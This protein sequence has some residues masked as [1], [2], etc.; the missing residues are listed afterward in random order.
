MQDLARGPHISH[1]DNTPTRIELRWSAVVIGMVVGLLL[2]VLFM[3]GV[4]L[5]QILYLALHGI[6][7]QTHNLVVGGFQFPLCA[8]DSGMYLSYLVTLGVVVARGRGLAGRLPPLRI[9]LTILLLFVIMGVDGVNSTLAEFDFPHAYTPRDDLRLVTGMGA[10]IGLALVVLLVINTALRRDVQ[11]QLHSLGTWRE[12][13]MI[14]L[15]NAIIVALIYT[16]L[17]IVAV[18]LAL[19]SAAAVLLNLALVMMLIPSLFLGLGGRVTRTTQLAH[20]AFIGL[21]LG[22]TFLIALARYRI[23]MEVTGVLPPPL[24]P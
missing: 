14:I 22:L 18:P 20:P 10:G 21:V 1:L 12:L 11:D 3:P 13:G 23:W 9:S 7:A 6:C 2:G 16:N 19:L 15:I 4:T 8:R 24:V 17:L 5:E